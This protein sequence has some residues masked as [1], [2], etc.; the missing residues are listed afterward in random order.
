M[1][2]NKKKV[3][4]ISFSLTKNQIDLNFFSRRKRQIIR[5]KLMLRL[6]LYKSYRRPKMNLKSS[7]MP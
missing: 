3:N 7:F 6:S 5:Y 1:E 4:K 2:T